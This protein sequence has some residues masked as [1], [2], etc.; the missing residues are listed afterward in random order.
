METQCENGVLILMPKGELG[1]IEEP[2]IKDVT[3]KIR[4]QSIQHVVFDLSK[5]DL[6]SS[7]GFGWMFGIAG[8]CTRLGVSVAACEANSVVSRSLKWVNGHLVM[9]VCKSRAEALLH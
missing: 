5:A 6:I 8:E 1:K 9:T 3:E 4:N 2:S 7:P